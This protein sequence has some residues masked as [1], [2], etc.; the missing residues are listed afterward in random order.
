M[1]CKYNMILLEYITGKAIFK[2][3]LGAMPTD[4]FEISLYFVKKKKKNLLKCF[5]NFIVMIVIG[6][7]KAKNNLS[8]KFNI[9]T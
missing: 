2:S 6:N 7:N 8:R 3:N 9:Y 5:P 4:I 1:L